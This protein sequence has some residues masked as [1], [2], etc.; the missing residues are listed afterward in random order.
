MS[1]GTWRNTERTGQRTVTKLST[2]ARQI[3]K[4]RHVDIDLTQWCPRCKRPQVF[5]EVKRYLV[6]DYEWEQVRR[7]AA[8]YSHDCI[9]ILVIE[10]LDDIGVKVYD[11]AFDLL[12]DVTWGGEEYLTRV[13]ERARD[14]HVCW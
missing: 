6:S 14:I 7:H 9:A 3:D 13:L 8:F 2:V 1:P 4:V 12:T 5:A 10:T 11:P